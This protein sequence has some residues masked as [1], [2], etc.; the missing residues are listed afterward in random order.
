[1]V[2][3]W[4]QAGVWEAG[5]VTYPEAGTP[6]GGVITPWTHLVTSSLRPDCR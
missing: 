3:K 2:G 1:L 6:Q 5:Q 4:L